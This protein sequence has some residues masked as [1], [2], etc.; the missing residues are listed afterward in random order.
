MLGAL[1]PPQHYTHMGIVIDNSGSAVRHATMCDKQPQA[2]ETSLDPIKLRYG[3]PGSITQ[4]VAGAR[5]AEGLDGDHP[6]AAP[7]DPNVKITCVQDSK[8]Y[9][10]QAL[11]FTPAWIPGSWTSPLGDIAPSTGGFAP[12]LLVTG[13]Y[14]V[15]TTKGPFMDP[16]QA[17]HF[18]EKVAD[19]AQLVR[20][21][22]RHFAYTKSEIALTP[23]ANGPVEYE[24]QTPNQA[25]PCSSLPTC[26]TIPAQCA[27]FAWYAIKVVEA[28]S[29]VALFPGFF[30]YRAPGASSGL[31]KYT[32]S[33]RTDAGSA[34]FKHLHDTIAEKIRKKIMDALVAAPLIPNLLGLRG[35]LC[36]F[37]YSVL[38]D[39]A[40]LAS[41]PTVMAIWLSNPVT[42]VTVAPLQVVVANIVTSL[43]TD[44]GGIEGLPTRLPNQ[45][46]NSFALDAQTDQTSLWSNPGDGSA[47][48]PDDTALG[49]PQISSIYD[50]VVPT[51]FV[52]ATVVKTKKTAWALSA[53]LAPFSGTVTYLGHPVANARVRVCCSVA[54]TD[55]NGKFHFG[56]MN[57][58]GHLSGMPAG[59]YMVW[60]DYYSSA[61]R[62]TIS[63]APRP[64]N[65]PFPGGLN[66]PAP[67]V[68]RPPSEDFRY[69]QF[70]GYVHILSKVT[71]GHDSSSSTEHDGVA[72]LGLY[73]L[74]DSSVGKSATFIVGPLDCFDYDGH[75]EGTATLTVYVERWSSGRV[76]VI[77][78]FAYKD[79]DTGSFEVDGSQVVAPGDT[80]HI[81][82]GKLKINTNET[83]SDE[84]TADFIVVNA[85][86]VDPTGV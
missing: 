41:W 3:W 8:D 13:G 61:D 34:L 73:N 20:A 79:D 21:H 59:K 80:L 54:T 69:V 27:S 85:Q 81:D 1:K 5:L 10:V 84:A 42:G 66:D 2:T 18:R 38:V 17:E 65:V 35:T 68:L 40:S 75:N 55:D 43:L 11:S 57:P 7:S 64:V 83:P 46:S 45:V 29:G 23:S 39:G 16:T 74:N 49:W 53:G 33:E 4:S 76:N 82:A 31:F 67:Y 26:A 52:P 60:V 24:D 30:S 50:T 25:D 47:V 56:A 9:I 19:A 37:I 12:L 86:A 48:S 58:L 32:K 62:L 71:L 6:E 44:L 36:D 14:G 22:Y 77:W 72:N 28:S 51:Q 15:R 63:A 70:H 78:K